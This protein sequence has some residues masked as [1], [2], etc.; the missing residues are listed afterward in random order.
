MKPFYWLMVSRCDQ[1][2]LFWIDGQNHV[3]LKTVNFG[4]ITTSTTQ[5]PC[6]QYKTLQVLKNS[7]DLQDNFNIDVLDQP[8]NKT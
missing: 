2:L 1:G 7:K 5:V 3:S 8:F 6:I 4:T